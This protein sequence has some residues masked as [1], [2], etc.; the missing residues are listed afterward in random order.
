MSEA[1]DYWN[2][3]ESEQ[4]RPAKEKTLHPP[5]GPYIIRCADVFAAPP[6]K[7]QKTGNPYPRIML[8]SLSE[9]RDNEGKPLW[10]F[11]T[12]GTRMGTGKKGKP[13]LRVIAEAYLGHVMGEQE[14]R[15]ISPKALA[16]L[17]IGRYAQ[18]TV[19]HWG[20]GKGAQIDTFMPLREGTVTPEIDLREYARPEKMDKVAREQGW[21]S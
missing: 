16:D 5:G 8:I 4:E 9:Q 7:D 11:T 2:T 15:D 20:A 18:G 6:G 12:V 21:V 19:S 1:N 13:R 10:L 3:P 14:A 17:L